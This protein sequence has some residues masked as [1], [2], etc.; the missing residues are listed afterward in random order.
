LDFSEFAVGS[1]KSDNAFEGPLPV[2][3]SSFSSNIDGI[4]VKLNWTTESEI[5]NSGFEVQ[6]SNKDINIWNKVGFIAGNG[7]K[8]TPSSYTFEDKKLNIGKYR[9]RLKQ[10]DYNGN[11]QF[12]ALSGFI[13]VA[14]PKLYELSQNYP[15]PFNPITK[16]DYN[17]PN[18]SKVSLIIYDVTGREIKV[19]VNEL[20]KAGYYS[21]T[22]N[23]AN[24]ASGIYFYRL[25]GN[26]FDKTKKMVLIK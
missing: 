10:I 22:F 18:D 26:N 3:L 15:N 1:N 11:Y 5:N 19:L 6:R 14:S 4:N 24:L 8:Q 16:I 21:V 12:Y 9:Y 25:I 20:Q 2:L 23:A 7:T 13:D 17:L